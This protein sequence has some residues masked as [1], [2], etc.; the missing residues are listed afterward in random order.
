MS[1]RIW[2]FQLAPV[3]SQDILMPAGARILTVQT[4][5][6][7]LCLWALVDPQARTK[8]RDIRIVGTGHQA[9]MNTMQ[10]LGTAQMVGGALVW[11]VFEE[12]PD[13]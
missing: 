5:R 3:E 12:A 9:D 13:A 8:P 6:D 1:E 2:K 10:Y 7:V 4:Q 11:H